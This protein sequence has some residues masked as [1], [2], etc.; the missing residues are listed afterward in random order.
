[1]LL[2]YVSLL[3]FSIYS[4][5]RNL[6]RTLLP[7]ISWSTSKTHPPPLNRPTPNL[8]IL[9]FPYLQTVPNL[10][11]GNSFTLPFSNRIQPRL[12][13]ATTPLGSSPPRR[14]SISTILQW[15]R[16]G[17]SNGISSRLCSAMFYNKTLSEDGW[18]SEMMS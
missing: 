3:Y 15:K 18:I 1:M 11:L 7:A 6:G 8:F 2:R 10:V 14:L 13:T 5:R 17:A 12:Q 4:S 16:W 9:S